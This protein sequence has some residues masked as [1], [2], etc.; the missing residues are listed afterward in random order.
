MGY[1]EIINRP[2]ILVAYNHKSLLLTVP[3]DPSRVGGGDKRVSAPS[4]PHF[5]SS[6]HWTIA[7]H[8]GR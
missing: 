5:G 4:H 6:H 3:P 1:A 2:I 7:N 8:L